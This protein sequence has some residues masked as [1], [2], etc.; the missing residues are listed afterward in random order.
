MNNGAAQLVTALSTAADSGGVVELQ[1][2]LG[3]T[4]LSIVG[5]AAYGCVMSS[6]MK[7]CVMR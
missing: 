6:V 3:A 5:A 2:L 1:P 7:P 4:T